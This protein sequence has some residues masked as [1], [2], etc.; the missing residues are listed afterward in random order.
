[1]RFACEM[2]AGV[3]GDLFHFTSERSEDISQWRKPLFHIGVSRYFTC[4]VPGNRQ[5]SEA[6]GFLLD[7]TVG[8]LAE[9]PQGCTAERK[10]THT[11]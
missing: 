8:A 9:M 10:N 1:M 3:K 11:D 4:F 6:E 5:Q 2:P 7:S